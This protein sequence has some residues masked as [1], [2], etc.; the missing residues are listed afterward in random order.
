M[1]VN[2]QI[3]YKRAIETVRNAT[4]IFD[5]KKKSRAKSSMPK[6]E[7]SRSRHLDGRRERS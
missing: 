6:K 7:S 5:D 2:N 3:D 1:V 4:F